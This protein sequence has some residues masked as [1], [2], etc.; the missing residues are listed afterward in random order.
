MTDHRMF[1]DWL[2]ARAREVGTDN[3]MTVHRT[4]AS[5]LYVRAREVG[6]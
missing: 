1:A 3:T 5:G 4:F 2:Y 6:A